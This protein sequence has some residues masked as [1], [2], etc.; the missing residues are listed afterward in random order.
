M[1][2]RD[3]TRSRNLSHAFA[4]SRSLVICAELVIWRKNRTYAISTDVKKLWK[5]DPSYS[6]L[7]LSG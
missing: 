2:I 5:A 7:W 6:F 4:V 3:F 1:L